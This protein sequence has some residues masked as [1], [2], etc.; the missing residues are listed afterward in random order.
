MQEPRSFRD[1]N[2]APEIATKK[3]EPESPG[4]PVDWLPGLNLEHVAAP[5]CKFLAAPS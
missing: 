2:A 1:R 5:A 3:P 4:C